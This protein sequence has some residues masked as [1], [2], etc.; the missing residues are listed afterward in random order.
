MG[1]IRARRIGVAPTLDFEVAAGISGDRIG[2]VQQ[3]NN[4]GGVE[5][6]VDDLGAIAA[7][8]NLLWGNRGNTATIKIVD[9][10]TGEPLSNSPDLAHAYYWAPFILIGNGL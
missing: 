3:Q 1:M 9:P 10:R 5:L 7:G 2:T 8:K 6:L 4:V